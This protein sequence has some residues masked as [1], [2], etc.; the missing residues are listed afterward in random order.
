M[1]LQSSLIALPIISISFLG[2]STLMIFVSWN[3]LKPKVAKVE[4]D[5][6]TYD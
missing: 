4:N 6:H 3:P 1:P 5:E 2:S